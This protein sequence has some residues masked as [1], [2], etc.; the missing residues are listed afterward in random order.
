M[1]C[2]V[3]S[4]Y[5]HIT[6]A[7]QPTW[8]KWPFGLNT[9]QHMVHQTLNGVMLCSWEGHGCYQKCLVQ[10]RLEKLRALQVFGNKINSLLNAFKR[11]S[12][13]TNELSDT[14]SKVHAL[15]LHA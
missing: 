2:V 14:R 3:I 7:L 5:E 12:K 11:R 13:P 6:Q 9:V 10:Q 4:T 1:L 15:R 8:R